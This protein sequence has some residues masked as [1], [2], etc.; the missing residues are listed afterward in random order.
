[1]VRLLPRRELFAVFHKDRFSDRPFSYYIL[2]IYRMVFNLS[3]K[4]LRMTR[5]VIQNVKI[6]KNLNWD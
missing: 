3:A 5:P 4:Y 1:M 6:L 2:T